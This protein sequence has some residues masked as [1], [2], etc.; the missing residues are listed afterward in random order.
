MKSNFT[1]RILAGVASAC[2][3]VCMTV[4]SSASNSTISYTKDVTQTEA[5]SEALEALK[6]AEQEFEKQQ[7]L[8]DLEEMKTS[9][10]S[11]YSA[12]ST[13][14]ASTYNSSAIGN[15]APIIGEIEA[16]EY[17]KSLEALKLADMNYTE[18]CSSLGVNKT[19]KTILDVNN[20]IRSNSVQSYSN[21]NDSLELPIKQFPQERDYWCG[22]AAIQSLLDYEGIDMTQEEIANEVYDPNKSCL[23]YTINGT[24][25]SQYPVPR[26]LQKY[27]GFSYV[28]YP[29]NQAGAK[30]LTENDIKPKIMSTLSDG[31]GVLAV[32]ESYRK[33]DKSN[34][35]LPG[36]PLESK[37]HWI[38]INGYKSDGSEVCIAD[39]AKSPA[40]YWSGSISAY[41]SIP[42]KKL[43]SFATMRG[44][45][46]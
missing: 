30:V 34:S 12:L 5:Y 29:I 44:I 39:P 46:W 45:I 11:R 36:Y 27:T 14:E 13:T 41:Y 35:L 42:T 37:T 16:S 20:N 6:R 17:W 38:A 8:A 9:R 43:A 22:Y 7:A 10:I 40:V 3:A 28:P 4:T 1:K 2:A 15:N 33:N 25:S 24:S 31:Y 26:F 18:V 19:Y 23:W 21:Y 32:G